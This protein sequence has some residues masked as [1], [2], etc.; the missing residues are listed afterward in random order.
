MH[1][2]STQISVDH[3]KLGTRKK[4][5]KITQN[6][7]KLSHEHSKKLTTYRVLDTPKWLFISGPDQL[8]HA[9]KKKKAPKKTLQIP[10][11]SDIPKMAFYFWTKP[12]GA[13]KSH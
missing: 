13:C 9:K 6:H 11:F 12:I 5:L 10:L 8:A 7:A 2:K 3:Q 1:P 4:P